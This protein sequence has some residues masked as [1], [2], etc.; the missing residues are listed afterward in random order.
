MKRLLLVWGLAGALAGCAD[1]PRV[2][3]TEASALEGH[4][5]ALDANGDGVLD[6][7]EYESTRWN[8]PPFAT[9]DR[10][11]DGQ[12]SAVELAWLVR[13][14][15]ARHFD[16][17]VQGS[18]LPEVDRSTAEPRSTASPSREPGEGSSVSEPP[19][20]SGTQ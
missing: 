11:G 9:A 2:T 16:G 5:R 14:Q 17:V 18:V 13:R 15:S 12:I 8:G 20:A 6:R 4:R 10:D 19:A 7:N 1:R 3:W